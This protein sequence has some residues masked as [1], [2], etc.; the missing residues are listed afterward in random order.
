MRPE[1]HFR[2]ELALVLLLADVR[3]DVFTQLTLVSPRAAA[4]LAL[5]WLLPS[6]N[7]LVV[8]QSGARRQLLVADVAL[9]S[10]L[11]GVHPHV[12]PQQT[13][14]REQLAAFCA[15]VAALRHV[16][17]PVPVEAVDGREELGAELALQRRLL[18]MH[19]LDVH[20]QLCFLLEGG[21]TLLALKRPLPSVSAHVLLQHR[22]TPERLAA[23]ATRHALLQAKVN[24][25]IVTFQCLFRGVGTRALIAG[26]LARAVSPLHVLA[27]CVVVAEIL[28]TQVAFKL[29]RFTV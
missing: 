28:V 23:L 8:L 15:C 26:E 5:E 20:I 2:A 10:L 3:F 22:V 7:Q 12:V 1:E 19:A 6:V 4:V 25:H 9:V 14:G 17:P 13:D 24:L 27:P 11:A 18:L 16:Q 21:A 29:F